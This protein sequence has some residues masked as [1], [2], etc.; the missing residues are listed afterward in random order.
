VNT[1]GL[2]LVRRKDLLSAIAS[3]HLGKKFKHYMGKTQVKVSST[4]T[5]V[6]A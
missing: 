1:P 3:L 4:L 2:W 5:C 6:L